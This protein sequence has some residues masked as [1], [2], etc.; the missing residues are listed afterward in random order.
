MIMGVSMMIVWLVLLIVFVIVEAVTVQLVSAWFAVGALAGLIAYFCGANLT[1][2]FVVFLAV[3]IICFIFTR[4]LVKKFTATKIQPTNA[5]SCIGKEAVVL[6]AINN[7]EATGQVKV[8]G[9][10]WSAR[11]EDSSIISAGDI[12]IIRKIE[13]VKL[14]VYK[15]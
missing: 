2:Q 10:V 3:S 7:I 6:E 4:P 14:I 12:V 1:I 15:K 9:N 13:G 5:D 11:S 8:N